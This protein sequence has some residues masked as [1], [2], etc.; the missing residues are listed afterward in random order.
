[1]SRDLF[2]PHRFGEYFLLDYLGQGGMAEVLLAAP[3]PPGVSETEIR[4]CCLK[5][6]FP[7][8]STSRT[9]V[10]RLVAEAKIA[11]LLRHP[12]LVEVFDLGTSGTDFFLK[13][14]WV[15]GKRLDE[16]L[17]RLSDRGE[18]LP[19]PLA[20]AITREIASALQSVHTACDSVG[21]SLALVHCDVT[22][23]NILLSYDGDVKLA[24]FGI[25]T[26]ER[27][28]RSGGDRPPGK[29]AYMAPEQLSGAA[30]RRTD[31]YAL[32]VVLFEMVTGK[33][34][35]EGASSVA[36]QELIHSSNPDLDH[37]R[38][39]DHTLLREILRVL[40][41]KDP[42][43]RPSSADDLLKRLPSASGSA[44]TDLRALMEGTFPEE[45][46][47]E[48]RRRAYGLERMRCEPIAPDELLAGVPLGDGS[49]IKPEITDPVEPS[50]PAAVTRVTLSPSPSSGDKVAR[51]GL[52]KRL[53]KRTFHPAPV[54]AE[55]PPV[56][57][58]EKSSTPG[59][60][61]KEVSVSDIGISA[62]TF[63]PIEPSPP[64]PPPPPLFE[65]TDSIR[66]SRRLLKQIG[67]GIGTV[68][69]L[70]ALFHFGRSWMD[71]SGAKLLLPVRTVEIDVAIEGAGTNAD[72]QALDSWM[73]DMARM[74]LWQEPV[75]RLFASEY[76][77]YTDRNDPPFTISIGHPK[78]GAPPVHWGGSLFNR[79]LP[80]DELAAH[81]GLA[82]NLA[83][84]TVA[85][86][87]V[88][89][90]P[91]TFEE[92]PKYPLESM[93][94]RPQ[95]QGIVYIP[96]S[97]REAGES[98][99]RLAHEIAHAL[100][101]RDKFDERGLPPYPD[102]FVEPKLD[103]LF[104]QRFGEIMSRGIP[105]SSERY[106]PFQELAQ[107]KVG[108]QTAAEIGWITSERATALSRK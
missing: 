51:V 69:L 60:I 50:N 24:D 70:F 66:I 71:S 77:R 29:L 108:A 57:P 106:R 98:R 61:L 85:H 16:L 39:A 42:H 17:K 75:S 12:N 64:S 35:F 41:S 95:R 45:R 91:K 15:D 47:K 73:N 103:P 30:E 36:L 9:F 49:A 37:P 83:G 32:G 102:G 92:S 38:L 27:A 19:L 58:H 44:R 96:L 63:K 62:P 18:F 101:A 28:E 67:I 3:F 105:E 40:L 87:F 59:M 14:E 31:L 54:P 89:L 4:Y 46:E 93:E 76:R 99:V 100:G 5:K 25:A 79:N 6:L 84:T 65:I 22:P 68:A 34:P 26:A 52:L 86:V 80:F 21:R 53:V 81:L 43:T 90:Y 1:M 33:R 74:N 7:R 20:I 56:P 48:R 11:V 23:Q 88:L 72:P 2:Q 104:P 10:Q 82:R 97:Y 13:M 8:Y 78:P 94:N 107:V 55:Q